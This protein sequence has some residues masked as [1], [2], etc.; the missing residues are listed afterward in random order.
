M[1]KGAEVV[2]RTIR[3][4]I[5]DWIRYTDPV[6]ESTSRQ[7]AS[8]L[9]RSARIRAHLS[10]PQLAVS[11]GVSRSVIYDIEA[12]RRQPSLPVLQKVLSGS[13][14][15]LRLQLEPIDRE[16]ELL[17]E[18]YEQL[19]DEGRRRTDDRHARN[20]AAFTSASRAE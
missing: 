14:L 9:V 17:L 8:A 11:S 15:E 18:A 3:G 5:L 2:A 10:V 19:D 7:L 12:G 1:H 16:D 4:M 20:V 13:G 6:S